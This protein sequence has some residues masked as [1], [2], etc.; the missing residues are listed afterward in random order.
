MVGVDLYGWDESAG[1][2][3]YAVTT[4][5]PTTN[6]TNTVLL[7]GNINATQARKWM[8]LW[9]SYDNAVAAS[10]GVPSAA[11]TKVM[12][13]LMEPPERRTRRPVVWYGTSI[14]QGGVASRPGHTFTAMISSMLN[15]DVVNHNHTSSCKRLFL[16]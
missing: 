5:P 15:R 7:L 10:I 13:A 3:R 9:P 11:G 8:V 6:D 4:S 2:W 14:A 12:P 16:A 1:R